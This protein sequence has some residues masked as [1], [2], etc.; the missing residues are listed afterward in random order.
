[1]AYLNLVY[2]RK[3]DTAG[4]EGEREQLVKMA[5]DLVDK[6]KDIKEKGRKRPANPKLARG[7]EF[8]LFPSSALRW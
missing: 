8:M 7:K 6:V 4:S 5:E 2:R 3:A 1:M